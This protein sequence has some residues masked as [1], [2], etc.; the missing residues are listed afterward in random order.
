M[1]RDL[2]KHPLLNRLCRMWW[3][4]RWIWVC[5]VRG[6]TRVVVFT[7]W[8]RRRSSK[9]RYCS[10]WFCGEVYYNLISNNLSIRLRI[11]ILEVRSWSF[12]SKWSI[13]K[14]RDRRGLKKLMSFLRILSIWIRINVGTDWGRTSIIEN[15]LLRSVRIA[16]WNMI[17]DQWPHFLKNI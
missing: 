10:G 11:W 14:R 3:A 16:C 12:S 7:R 13:N 17:G 2:R 6:P 5:L 1:D 15:W 9:G 4:G 8:K